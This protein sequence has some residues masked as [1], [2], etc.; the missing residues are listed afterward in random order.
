MLRSRWRES[1]LWSFWNR[2]R[3]GSVLQHTRDYLPFGNR[4]ELKIQNIKFSIGFLFCFFCGHMCLSNLD[5]RIRM[6]KRLWGF[7]ESTPKLMGRPPTKPP[8]TWGLT[9]FLKT[10]TK[11]LQKVF[12]HQLSCQQSPW[13]VEFALA[14]PPLINPTPANRTSPLVSKHSN[15]CPRL[16]VRCHPALAPEPTVLF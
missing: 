5:H 2:D 6:L 8:D 12:K 9:L 10:S 11:S 13:L 15:I 3:T 1:I 4:Q 7:I 16:C 14:P